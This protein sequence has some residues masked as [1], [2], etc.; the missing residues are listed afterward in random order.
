MGISIAS[1]GDLGKTAS[2]FVRGTNPDHVLVLIDG[3][4]IGAATT[5]SAAWEQL[6][7]QQIDHLEIVRGPTSSLYG[8]E[9]LGG[10]VQIFTRHGVPG[11]PDLPSFEMSAGS[12]GTSL[13]EVGYSGSAGSGWDN[14]SASG[15]YTRGIDRKSTRLNSSHLV[16]S[17]AVFC[18]KK[19]KTT[20][21]A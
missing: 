10:V 11:A 13:G 16:I 21:N 4:K 14:A 15:L 17:Y 1:N 20:H 7:V 2:V 8:S 5:G 9:A 19:K 3:I 6:P 18:L 12:H